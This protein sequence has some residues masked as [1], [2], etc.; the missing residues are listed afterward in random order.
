MGKKWCWIGV[1]VLILIGSLTWSSMAEGTGKTLVQGRVWSKYDMELYGRVK[2]DLH[3]DTVAF[4]AYNDFI[5]VI[6]DKPDYKVDSIDFNPRDTRFGFKVR[7]TSGNW[8]GLG[9]FE[10]DFYGGTFGNNIAPR[11]R[12]AYVDLNNK[13]T[14]TDLRIGQDWVPVAQQN[15]HMSEFGIL[16][17]G[18]NLWWRIPQVTLRQRLS[19][20]EFLFSL[21]RHR[22]TSPEDNRWSWPWI[23]GRIAYNLPFFDKGSLIA[24]GGGYMTEKAKSATQ[25]GSDV[26]FNSTPDLRLHKWLAVFEYRLRKNPVEIKGEAWVGQGIG[27][28]WLRY[29]MDYNPFTG[30]EIRSQGGFISLLYKTPIKKLALAGGFGIDHNTTSDL[31]KFDWGQSGDYDFYKRRFK[32]NMQWFGNIQY[33]VTPGIKFIFEYIHMNTMRDTVRQGNRITFSTFYSF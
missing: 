7:H 9:R 26:T 8:V 30:D 3:Y 22:R 11:I 19:D 18:G 17:A 29:D 21:M 14:K 5:G 12:L 27:G 15:P 1:M 25:S 23:L 33:Q 13:E 2:I 31:K 24:I 10:M 4:D 20:F 6:S 16:T 28:H 32:Q